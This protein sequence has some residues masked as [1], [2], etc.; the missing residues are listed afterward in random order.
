MKDKY[1]WQFLS[2]LISLV[3]DE[4]QKLI[5]KKAQPRLIEIAEGADAEEIGQIKFFLD[6]VGVDLE[7]IRKIMLFNLE[8]HART[9]SKLL[10]NK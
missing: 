3:S 4:R 9:K 5:V 2:V 10:V 8:T 1:S 7:D 6:T